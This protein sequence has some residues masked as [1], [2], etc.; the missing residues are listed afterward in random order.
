MNYGDKLRNLR[1][2]LE[3]TQQEIADKISINRVQYNQYENDYNTIPLRHL[4][5][6][7][8]FF[9]VSLD[10]IFDFTSKLQYNKVKMDIDVD[11]LK[12]R[13]KEFRQENKI[14]QKVLAID[15]NVSR[16]TIAEYER[17]I[18]L[19]STSFLY[20]ICK[21]YNISADYLLGRIDKPK[22]LK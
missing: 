11:L 14:T 2:E 18:N 10:Y 5:K 13:L 6:L 9:N 8:N 7:C 22:Y 20:S 16:T 15:F 21:T 17:G 4:V 12:I 3:L 1:E 19:I